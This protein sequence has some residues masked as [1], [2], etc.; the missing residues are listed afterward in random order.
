MCSI[1]ATTK[2]VTNLQYVNYYTKFRGPDS[3]RMETC[4]PFTLV[5]NLLSITGVATTQ[6]FIEDGTATLFNGE[7][8]NYT[9]FGSYKSDGEVLLPLYREHGKDFISKL[10][11]EFSIFLIDLARGQYVVS[12]DVFGTKP[13]WIAFD[14]ENVGVASY[15]SVLRRLGF[16]NPERVPANTTRIYDSATHMLV[17][18]QPV[19][20]FNLEQ[21]VD[22]Y[23]LFLSAFAESIRK[24]SQD[25]SKK[26]FLGVSSG[27]DSGAIACELK[28]QGVEFK[29][30]SISGRENE[31]V[32]SARLALHNPSE[33]FKLSH[34]EF[35]TAKE[36]LIHCGEDMYL[37]IDTEQHRGHF[38]FE[39]DGAV[40]LSAICLRAKKDEY[41]V[42]FSG[43]GADEIFSDYGH[44]GHKFVSRSS[45][46]GLFP[47]QLEAIFPWKNFYDGTQRAYLD[48]EEVVA[49][50]HGIETRYPFLDVAL[51]QAFLN[52]KPELKNRNYKAP[53]YEYLMRNHY[54]MESAQKIGFILE[55]F[56]KVEK[57]HPRALLHRLYG[58]LHTYVK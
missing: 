49:G 17:H 33:Y 39:N 25:V 41:K 52:L 38:V 21:K 32:L 34:E 22:S 56:T 19:Y 51:V 37:A 30:F 53:L 24:R 48:K 46:G 50:S 4:G 36:H 13:L 16:K 57:L 42:F 54:P 20:V 9:E 11:G 29:V 58:Y 45:F 2:E 1:I 18:E 47:E 15:A 27:Y 26:I 23:D 43:Q 7:I 35:L 5:H 40:G 44:N 6:P 28:Q 8:Y 14:G 55:P 3:T 12:T 31:D 10:D